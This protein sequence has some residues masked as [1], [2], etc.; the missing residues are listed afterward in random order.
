MSWIIKQLFIA[1]LIFNG[2]IATKYTKICVP[3]ETKDANI[4]FL[5]NYNKNKLS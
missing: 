2:S 5:K 4:N 1:L 3:S